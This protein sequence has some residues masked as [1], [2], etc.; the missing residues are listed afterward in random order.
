MTVIY[1]C[2]LKTKTCSVYCPYV[3]HLNRQQTAFALGNRLSGRCCHL[4]T[5]YCCG[6]FFFLPRTFLSVYFVIVI[7]YLLCSALQWQT[8]RQ[9]WSIKAYCDASWQVNTNHC[10]RQIVIFHLPKLLK[11]TQTLNEKCM[12]WEATFLLTVEI[13]VL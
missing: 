7:V 8:E 13:L 5:K 12:M 9:R 11:T 4:S 6:N 2:N 1:L 3:V 10:H